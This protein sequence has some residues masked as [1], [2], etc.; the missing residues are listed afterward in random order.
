VGALGG[1]E[2]PAVTRCPVEMV[3]HAL[4]DREEARIAVDDEPSRVDPDPARICEERPEHLGDP[5]ARRGRVDVEDGPTG[6]R[7]ACSPSGLVEPLRAFRSDE[8]R[9]SLGG[10]RLDLYFLE[11]HRHREVRAAATV[12][13]LIVSLPHSCRKAAM[14]GR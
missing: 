13:S 14:T 9:Q 7:V 4:R 3:V 1:F 5:A 6:Q 10:Q 12:V 2:R 8:R 11:F